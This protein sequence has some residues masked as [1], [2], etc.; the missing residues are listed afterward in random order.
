MLITSNLTLKR[1]QFCIPREGNPGN[2]LLTS[3]N[4]LKYFYQ[5]L[6]WESCQIVRHLRAE[7]RTIH[8]KKLLIIENYLIIHTCRLSMCSFQ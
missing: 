3:R 5:C 8:G 2:V 1:K 4:S 6:Y 7:E